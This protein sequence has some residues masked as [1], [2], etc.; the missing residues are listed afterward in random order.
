MRGPRSLAV[1]YGLTAVSGVAGLFALNSAPPV[2]WSLV[3]VMSCL[4]SA[5]GVMLARVPVRSRRVLT[6]L[7]GRPRRRREVA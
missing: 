6:L 7:S 3:A 2:A 5:L 4:Y 1:V